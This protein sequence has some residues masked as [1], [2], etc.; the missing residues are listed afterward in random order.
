MRRVFLFG[1]FL[2]LVAALVVL[3]NHRFE[4]VPGLPVWRLADLRAGMPEVSGTDWMGTA[5]DPVLRLRVDAKTPRVALRLAVPGVPSVEMLHLRYR[6]VAR[7]LVRGPEKWHTGRMVI[8]W[9]ARDGS[10]APEMDPVGGI[11]LDADSG[12]V[13]LVAIPDEGPAVPALRLEHLGLSGEWELSALEIAAAQERPLWRVGSWMLSMCWMAWLFACLRSW[14]VVPIWRALGASSLW[15]LMGIHFAVPGPWRIQRPLAGDFRLGEIVAS[16][17]LKQ[18]P[19]LERNESSPAIYSKETA[20]QGDILPRGSLALRVKALIVWARPLLHSLLLCAPVLA[21]AW[22][23]GRRPTLVVAVLLS[24]AIE[25]AQVVFGY[26]FDWI[27]I[28]DLLADAAGIVLGLWLCRRF[29]WGRLKEW[30]PCI[31]GAAA[32]PGP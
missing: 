32:T 7:G 12:R 8:E 13:A 1:S 10:T 27:D 20:A 21:S 3:W 18:A 11:D 9:H 2:F 19:A 15:L 23:V 14:P 4:R 30:C 24:L 26:G 31:S 28:V 25:G 5:D 22:L 16:P 29:P 17:V 6:M